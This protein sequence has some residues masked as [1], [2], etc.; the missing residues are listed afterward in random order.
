MK[1]TLVGYT[2]FVGGNLAASHPFDLRYNSKNI[3]DA[4]SESHDLVVYA[5]MR[6]EKFLA[7]SDPEGDRRLAEEALHNI[8]RMAP[9]KLV[10]I[11]TVDVYKD[12]RGVDETTP[13]DTEGLH[14]YGYNR[15]LLE[16]WVQQEFPDCH[17]IRLPGLFGR[18]IKKNF[19]YDMMTLVPSML[20]E[21]KYLELSAKE[22]LVERGYTL[23]P[24]GFYK[25]SAE[26]EELEKLRLF[27]EGNDFNSLC[28]TDSRA[29]YQFYDLK[30][31]WKDINIAIQNDIR[32]LNISSEPVSAAEVYAFIKG[33]EFKNEISPSPV[34]Y[35]WRSVHAETF[36]GEGG[37]IYKKADILSAIREGVL[38]RELLK[39]HGE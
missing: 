15:Y 12:P 7:N 24:N 16:Q 6:A 33:G 39:K 35:D 5:G 14:P 21:D 36:G 29:V 3:T 2:G 22:P 18:G 37:Y 28:F 25:L 38:S 31:L 9:K 20:K 17:I 30:N 32:L 26:G 27:F 23:A 34:Y 1:T 11:S 13:I 19:I 4:F 8:R 10:L